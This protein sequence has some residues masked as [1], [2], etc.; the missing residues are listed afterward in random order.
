MALTAD[1]D[2]GHAA[3]LHLCGAVLDGKFGYAAAVQGLAGR[4]ERTF[5]AF[6][7]LWCAAG[8]TEIH[9]SLVEIARF[10]GS[11]KVGDE[12]VCQLLEKVF[13]LGR[14]DGCVYREDARQHAVGVSIHCSSPDAEG[15]R[16]N[17]RRR[18]GA[19]TLKT[20]DVGKVIGKA[21]AANYLA[22][23]LMKIAR[24]AVIAQPL[25][26]AQHLIFAGRGKAGD[27]REA[28]HKPFP[29]G[30]ALCNARL[31][32]DNLTKPY[33][34]GVARMAPRQVAAVLAVPAYKCGGKMVMGHA[35]SVACVHMRDKGP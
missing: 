20:P 5:G 1:E 26:H 29:V 32:H 22:C 2:V 12:A 6:W 19:H 10:F 18:V 16:G 4:H 24:A 3:F 33:G 17:G 25:P 27:G 9:H 7:S 28:A 21:A 8:G 11:G 30:P 14:I 31:L 34:I 23:S 15:K 35:T 13:T